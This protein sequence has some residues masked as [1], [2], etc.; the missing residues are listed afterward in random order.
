MGPVLFVKGRHDEFL[1]DGR[2]SEVLHQFIAHVE[3]PQFGIPN[4]PQSL[5]RIGNARR[6]VAG[7]SAGWI[8]ENLFDQS[9]PFGSEGNR[10]CP[11]IR[12]AVW[13]I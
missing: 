4:G 12:V 13:F 10:G 3:F 8:L 6:L 7:G 9:R 5:H 11:L 1:M 2:L